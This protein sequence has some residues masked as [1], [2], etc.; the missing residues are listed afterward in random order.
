LQDKVTQNW[1][2]F[3]VALGIEK[4]VL[5]RYLN[6]PPEQSIVEILDHLLRRDV[7]QLSW[8]EVAGA[9]RQI[10]F[11]QLAEEIESITETGNESP[12][13]N[14]N[15]IVVQFIIILILGR[16]LIEV[17]MDDVPDDLLHRSQFDLDDDEAPPPI[18]PKRFEEDPEESQ[19]DDILK[20]VLINIKNYNT[21]PFSLCRS[22]A[23]PIRPPKP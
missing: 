15:Y 16:L 10:N 21:L 7:E 3:G 14:N 18:P 6:Y 1:Y 23:A 20:Y 19:Y 2:Q 4:D 5:D 12:R 22:S 13:Q 9:L 11:H 8:M 17:N